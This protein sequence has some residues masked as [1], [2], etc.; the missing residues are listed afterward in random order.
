MIYRDT[1]YADLKFHPRV[2]SK[3]HRLLRVEDPVPSLVVERQ[4]AVL[5]VRTPTRQT[6][7]AAPPGESVGDRTPRQICEC[8]VVSPYAEIPRSDPLTFGDAVTFTEYLS[9]TC[10]ALRREARDRGDVTR[11]T[12]FVHD[13]DAL[14]CAV[15]HLKSHPEYQFKDDRIFAV[16]LEVARVH[17]DAD[18][19]QAHAD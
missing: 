12:R 17:G 9:R 8:G 13:R 10:Q 16:G 15:R 11:A 7:R 14:F 5:P 4:G 3:C 18:S 1:L 2:C 19:D 6:L